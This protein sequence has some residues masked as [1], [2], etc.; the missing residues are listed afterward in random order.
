MEFGPGTYGPE[1]T[2]AIVLLFLVTLFVAYSN[3]ANDNFKG[4]ATLLGSRVASYR[5]AIT[6]AT[7]MTVAGSLCSL[8]LAENLTKAFSGQGLVPHEIA[9]SPHF[10][11]AVAAGA[12][13]T[14]ILATLLGFPVSTTHGL[15]GALIGAG[16]VATGGEIKLGF[17]G[18]TFLAPLVISPFLAIMLTMSLYKLLHI[19]RSRWVIN[20]ESCICLGETELMPTPNGSGAVVAGTAHQ[21]ITIGDTAVC[22]ETYTSR[23]CGVSTEHL[24]DG[25]HYLSA[26]AVC[27]ARALNDT[28]KIAGLVFAVH[29]LQLRFGIPAIALVMAIGGIVSARKVAHTMSWKI[30]RMND[31]QALTANMVS[32]LVVIFASRLGLPVSTTH[33]SVGAITGVGLINGSANSRAL[34]GILLS[35][36]LTLPV[37]AILSGLGYTLWLTTLAD[38]DS[39]PPVP[40]QLSV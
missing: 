9:V 35:W 4:V 1:P 27:F 6:L 36:F 23:Y 15:T 8:L 24:I 32:A 26:S 33:V 39:V 25:C 2:L 20:R 34:T 14:V 3:G 40:V 7:V 18:S 12:G 30:A 13:S 11:V 17:L 22:R 37:A 10:L 21:T 38:A 28:P 5:T 16:I 29:S 31:G 19:V